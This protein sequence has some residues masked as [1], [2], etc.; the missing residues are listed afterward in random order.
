MGAEE[1]TIRFWRS[2]RSRH[3]GRG[4]FGSTVVWCWKRR[5]NEAKERRGFV[6]G[7][8]MES[9]EPIR[10]RLF[11]WWERNSRDLPWRYGRT[12]PWGIL[13]SE[14]MSQQTQLSRVVPYWTAWMEAWPDA[15]ALAAAGKAEVITAWGRLGY[16]RRALRLQ[17]CARVV[18]TEYGD[19]L[20]RSY[21]ELTG[22]PGIGDY[23]ASAVMS[24]AYGERIVV[25][26]TNIR[27]VLSRVFLGVESVGGSTTRTE[28]ELAQTVLPEDVGS[29][30][31]KGRRDSVDGSM[32]G[33]TGQEPP[34]D[35]KDTGLVGRLGGADDQVRSNAWCEPDSA[36]W[37]QGIME[38]GATV[39]KAKKPDCQICPLAE[40]CRFLK[41]GLPELGMKR[42][43]PRQRFAGTNRQVR[44]KILQALRESEKGRVDRARIEQVCEDG[45]QLD[46]CIASLDEDGLLVIREDGSLELPE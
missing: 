43:R 11:S 16:P 19:L 22:L 4:R 29:L 37:N 38:L 26:D 21:Q 42:T 40:H 23:T 33:L 13:V 5:L 14:V 44:G 25:I 3:Q 39:C 41:A 45:I 7:I 27:R 36:K 34:V 35:T 2:Q 12:T 15:A 6:E 20:P 30:S 46:L 32:Q 10:L 1:E 31:G 18:S 28:R 17:E 9:V 24:F 8:L